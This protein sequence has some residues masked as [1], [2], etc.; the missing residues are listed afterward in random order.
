MLSAKILSRKRRCR[1]ALLLASLMVVMTG[2]VATQS[3]AASDESPLPL[4]SLFG[5]PFQLVDHNGKPKSDKDFRG[6]F[7][8]IYFGYTYCPDICPLNLQEMAFALEALGADAKKVQPIFI[9][10][11][12]G[13]DTPAD[14]KEYVANFDGDFI[15]LTGSEA[16]IQA[17]ARSYRVHRRKVIL[18]DQ[19]TENDYLVDHSSITHLV[20]PDGKFRTLF[21]HNTKGV[22]MAE[23]MRKYLK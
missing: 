9:S 13:R 15:A 21:P 12:P 11:D 17:V 2:G 1:I 7:M 22:V 8:L 23:R 10:I 5:G 16:Q 20:G 3:N 14:L 4:A 18:P 19:E 6:K